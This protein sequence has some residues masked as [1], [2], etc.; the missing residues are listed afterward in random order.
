[1]AVMG[2]YMMGDQKGGLSQRSADGEVIG[3]DANIRISDPKVG[4]RVMNFGGNV[5]A[6]YNL[7]QR[8]LHANI[9]RTK[10]M[11]GTVIWTTHERV[12]DGERGG[13]FVKG[14][15]N[16]KVKVT[17]KCIGPELIGKA[18][19]SNIS[20]DFGNTLHFI[21]ASKKEIAGQDPVTGKTVY[22]EKTDYRVYT[23][24]HYDPDGIVQLKYIAI[25]RSLHP[26]KIQDFYSSSADKP[27]EGLLEFYRDLKKAQ[28]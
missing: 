1:M 5:G 15:A 17:E 12:D 2:D 13:A 7:G 23:R 25:N 14:A 10:A 18:L 11:P 21:Q 9:I 28:L 19:T 4:D 20:R 26:A 3:Q 8:H 27:G 16:D 6:H 22:K 24:E